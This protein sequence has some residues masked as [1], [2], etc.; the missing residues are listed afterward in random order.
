MLRLGLLEAV[1]VC[2]LRRRFHLPLVSPFRGQLRG[3]LLA[4]FCT[5]VLIWGV[6]P[7]PSMLLAS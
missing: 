7:D 3:I 6:L 5:S 1:V 4:C 2:P